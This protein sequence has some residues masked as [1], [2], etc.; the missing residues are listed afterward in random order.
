MVGLSRTGTSMSNGSGD[1]VVAFSTAES[2]RRTPERRSGPTRYESLPNDLMTPLF[3]AVADAIEEAIYNS[4]F[5][6]TR[7]EANG[8]VLEPLPLAPFME[9]RTQD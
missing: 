3:V 7:M 2:A 8:R 5:Q 4:L 1:Y 9:R 6:A